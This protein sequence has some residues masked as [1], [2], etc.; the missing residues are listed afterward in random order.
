MALL[1]VSSPLNTIGVPSAKL[2]VWLN[3][4]LSTVYS[5]V[6]FKSGKVAVS[7]TFLGGI[8]L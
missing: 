2:P 5:V 7:L 6:L 3:G 8:K 1:Q 4:T